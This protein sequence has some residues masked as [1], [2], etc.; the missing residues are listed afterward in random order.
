MP[1]RSQGQAG[2]SVTPFQ[3]HAGAVVAGDT[4]AFEGT[5]NIVFHNDVINAGVA[6][7]I[8]GLDDDVASVPEDTHRDLAHDHERAREY[9]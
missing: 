1:A 2:A 6:N 9:R 7:D 4:A 5:G 3:G 8:M